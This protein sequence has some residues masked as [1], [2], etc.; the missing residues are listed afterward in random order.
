MFRGEV[1]P[2]RF[3]RGGDAHR[4]T[5]RG[6]STRIKVNPERRRDILERS[7]HFPGC[8]MRSAGPHLLTARRHRFL[9]FFANLVTLCTCLAW[10]APAQALTLSIGEPYRGRLVN[11]VPFPTDMGGYIVRDPDR[12]YATPELVGSLLDAIETVREKYPQTVDLFIGDF[13]APGGGPMRGHKSHQN[14]RDVDLGMYAIGNQPL[15]RF[16]PMHAGNL[17]V[18]KTWSLMEALIRT[19]R[20]QYLFVD[21]KIQRMLFEYALSRGFDEDLLNRLFNDVGS[22]SSEAAIRHEPLHDDHIHVRFY[23][24]WSTLAAQADSLDPDKKALIELA[25]AGFLPKKVLY[26]VDK[27]QTDIAALAQN[28]G[29][30]LQDLLRWNHLQP[31]M[32]L[33]PGTPLVYYRRAF[34]LEPVHL[35][36]SLRPRTIIPPEP[37]QVASVDYL[38]SVDVSR[39]KRSEPKEKVEKTHTVRRGETASSVAR[40]YGLSVSELCRLNNISAKKPL[41]V[42][43]K[44]VVARVF[45]DASAEKE[46]KDLKAPN[47]KTMKE[48][49]PQALGPKAAAPKSPSTHVVAKSDTLVSIAKK[50][51]VSVSDLRTWNNLP[52]T[53]SLKP[54][55][56]L[57]V[58]RPFPKPENPIKAQEDRPV[59]APTKGPSNPPVKTAT[60]LAPSS[61]STKNAKKPAN[62]AEEGR[63][64]PEAAAPTTRS[65]KEAPKPE[66]KNAESKDS[67]SFQKAVQT[68]AP[69]KNL[70]KTARKENA[71][72]PKIL[73]MNRSS[74]P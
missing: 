63:K 42:G 8:G 2:S 40:A 39:W 22:G 61:G 31:N 68:T 12:A 4:H 28:L 9:A 53:G 50:Y 36:E 74:R 55:S 54:G 20:V 60:P 62:G 21:R 16:I 41:P 38:P 24:P 29:V 56:T 11:G 7:A 64:A 71:T 27:R 33:S 69:G 58:S 6:Y 51:G 46:D 15:D 67:G 45:K 25:Q 5:I 70:E 52:S 26:Y 10:I 18:P 14:G 17:D 57:I 32:P 72:P 23:A 13:S 47:G 65:T 3:H 30:R 34:E 1:R 44:L 37:L 59:S 35:A 66:A 48:N 73:T 19:G 49:A 43:S